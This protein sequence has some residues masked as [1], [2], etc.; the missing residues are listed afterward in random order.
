MDYAENNPPENKIPAS[1]DEN[2]LVCEIEGS[3]YPLQGI[4]ADKLSGS[5]EVT[6]EW[7][8]LDRDTGSH[9][10]LDVFA[11]RRLADLGQVQPRAVLLVECKKSKN[12]YVFFRN[13]VDREIPR[14]PKVTG[15]RH[16]SVTL[17]ECSGKRSLEVSVSRLLGLNESEFVRS[18][19]ACCSAFTKAIAKGDKFEIS[20][21][22]PFNSLIL[23]LVKATDHT[24]SL[25]QPWADRPPFLPTLILSVSV[26]D[27]PMVLVKS[28]REA[29]RPLLVPWVR[30]S[31]Q[32]AH[33]DNSRMSY[34]YYV[35]DVV[36][37]GFLDEFIAKHLLPFI[38]E[39]RAHVLRQEE[40]ILQGGQ[41]EDVDNWRW[42]E[43][44]VIGTAKD[45][46]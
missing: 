45:G 3:G 21:T 9:R 23:P 41:V 2:N 8:Y 12:P 29:D 34:R 32:E 24:T 31:R 25:Y 7:C 27:A 15:L 10:S 1:M 40:V 13:V 46:R 43:I 28:P 5:F 18:G 30:V 35:I 37:I 33:T 4:V 19:P 22:D 6:E 14:F 38:E 20:G 26:L 17:R 42:D 16:H 39:F 36:H 11:F 44:Q